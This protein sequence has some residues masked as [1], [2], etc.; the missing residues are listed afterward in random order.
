MSRIRVYMAISLDGFV[1][2]AEHGVDWLPHEEVHE[3]EAL[4]F[5]E[6]I[7]QV[8]CMLMGRSTYDFVAGFDGPWSYP[9]RVPVL[10]ASTRDLTPKVPQVR[11][12]EGDIEELLAEAKREAGGLD[13]YLDGGRIVQAALEKDLVDELVL[14]RVPKALGAG[15]PLFAPPRKDFEIVSH[16]RYGSMLQTTLRPVRVQQG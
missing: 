5:G 13:V 14:T 15:I 16:A 8:G 6:F 11:R 12:V 4:G 1:A 7:E 3:T 10:V 2:D 9:E